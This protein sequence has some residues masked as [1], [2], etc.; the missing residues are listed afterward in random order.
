MD[1]DILTILYISAT[2]AVT[3]LILILFTYLMCYL[4]RKNSEHD[5]DYFFK[6]K[7]KH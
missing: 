6:S 3:A 1:M 7:D 4:M 2:F 5:D